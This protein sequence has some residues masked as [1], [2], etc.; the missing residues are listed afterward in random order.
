MKKYILRCTLVLAPIFMLSFCK[1]K[2]DKP[3]TMTPS[4]SVAQSASVTESPFGTLPDGTAVSLYT[5]KNTQGTEMKV[6]NYGGIIV[7]LKTAD[8]AGVF[9]DVVLGYDSLA[10][11]IKAPS[12][13]GALVGRYGNRIA[14]G[15]FT[16]DGKK[17]TLAKNNG[18]NHL[19]GGLKGFDKVVWAAT[20]SSSAEGASLKLTYLS[21]DMEEG[22]PG[23]LQVEVNYTLTN[24]NELK[25]DYSATT[26]KKTVINL[27]NHSYF[28]LSGNTKRDILDHVLT[29]SASK[30]LPVDKGLI[31][32]GELKNVAGTPFD[33]T[34]PTV[35]GDRI[36]S[37]DSQIKI[38]GGYDHCWVFDKPASALELGATLYDSTS[39]RFMEMYTT[40][41]GTQF[42][43]GNF[44]NGTVTGKFNTEYNKRYALCLET[45]H[46]P[47]SPNRPDFP[48]VVL[49]PGEV[50]K[51]QTTYKFSTK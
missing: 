46:F 41:P 11:Y 17:Y 38:G 22:Y 32:T 33:F 36:D 24:E 21:K 29:I 42:Y 4:D 5:F 20:P 9:E 3:E 39:G 16:L 47:D 2:S 12:F 6:T 1:T 44:L 45:Q 8:K 31:P 30:F 23:N 14:K 51:T 34:S 43:S 28:N 18:E 27:T 48:S 37:D 15:Q 13:F 25:I 10:G 7:S 49:S 26:D 50:Y 40:E 19:H 35:V